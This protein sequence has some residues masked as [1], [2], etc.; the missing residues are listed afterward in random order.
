M[1]RTPGINLGN[2]KWKSSLPHKRA[3][4]SPN[5]RPHAHPLHMSLPWTVLNK[6][7]FWQP[8]TF[9]GQSICLSLTQ[10]DVFNVSV[11]ATTFFSSKPRVFQFT[12]VLVTFSSLR[13]NTQHPQVEGG[14]VCFDL[15]FAEVSV[16]SWPAPR[17]DGMVGRPGQRKALTSQ[18]P[19]SQEHQGRSWERRY[20]LLGH[21][22]RNWPLLTGP[23][24]LTSHLAVQW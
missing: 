16:H 8:V 2:R 1:W 22:H 7:R 17:Q 19:W 3:L 21:T 13:P 10:T 18:H 11:W 24:V 15:Q 5:D 23:H 6:H 9:L 4:I 12:C 14:K 20:A